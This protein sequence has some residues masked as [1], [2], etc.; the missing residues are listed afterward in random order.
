MTERERL[1]R[2]FGI[3][4]V[5]PFAA[6]ALAAALGVVPLAW[7]GSAAI[8]LGVAGIYADEQR[9]IK[10]GLA[11]VAGWGF[12]VTGYRE[13]LLAREPAFDLELQRAMAIELLQASIAAVDPAI[14][15]E[16]RGDRVVRVVMR[17]IE[18]RAGDQVRAFLAGDRKRLAELHDR[19]LAPLHA[20]VGITALR[21]GEREELGA[22]VAAPSLT[23]PAGPAFREQAVV[24][25]PDLQSLVH[26]GTSQLD[27]P[28]EARS[29]ELREDRLLYATGQTPADTRIMA[30]VIFGGAI[31]GMIVA[32]MFAVVG[33]A[34]GTGL[35]IALRQNDR[36][37]LARA[38]ARATRWPFPID[39]Y[40]DWLL[41]GRPICDIEFGSP[42]DRDEVERKLRGVARAADIAWLTDRLVR[43]ESEP[44]MHV[45][46]HG[47]PS[48]WGGDPRELQQ[49]AR[50]VLV[51]L[52]ETH[53][54]VGVRMGG[55]LD[56][57]V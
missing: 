25:P 36:T 18:V 32:P 30:I 49:L 3:E 56:R 51:P 2:I 26:A 24:A 37:K 57:R 7:L 15:V 45:A 21:M 9:K 47:I 52:H 38:L 34:A 16:E 8:V 17:R 48:F 50:A 13:W 42:P 27:T 5:R 43:M 20:D 40:E 53:R 46:E 19:V 39:G 11:E 1:A 14:R 6:L 44:I 41:S 54:I 23:V 35:S 31:V 28:R 12:P 33:G 22:L 10:A 55:Y 29:I 4:P